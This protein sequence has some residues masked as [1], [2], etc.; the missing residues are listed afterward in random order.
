VTSSTRRRQPP[1]DADP[2]VGSAVAAAAA[3]LAAAAS[4]LALTLAHPPVGAWW[5]TFAAAPLLLLALHLDASAAERDGRAV[6]SARLGLVMGAAAFG[7]M[8]SWLILPAG[9]L[10]W[11]LLVATQAA[12]MAVLAIVLRLALGHPALP[13]VAAVAWV[14]VDAW[15][16]VVPLNGFEWGAIAYAH[17][18]GSWMLPVARLVGGRGI[19]FLVVVVGVAAFVMVRRTVAGL[20]ARESGPF[21][22]ALGPT[23]APAALLVGGLLVSVLATIEPPAEDGSLDI[24][25]V[26][27]NDIRHWEEPADD[28]PLTITTNLRDDTVAAVER[29]GSPDLTVWPESSIDRD[30]ATPRGASLAPLVDDAAAASGRLLAGASLDG[31]DPATE[32]FV[33]GLLFD[34]AA[35]AEIDRYVKR[36]LVPFGEYVPFR[37]VIGWFPPL[38]QI[39]RDAVPGED[40]QAVEVVDGVRAAVVVCFE[41]LFS[42]VVRTNVLADDEPAELLVTITNDAS[43]GISAEPAQHLAQ[44]RLRAVETGRWAVHAALSGSSAFIDPQGA[45]YQDTPLFERATIR[46]DVPLVEGRTPFLV[47]GDWLG[48]G[49]RLAV[50]GMVAL[51]A[52]GA[53]RRRAAAGD[54]DA[55]VAATDAAPGAGRR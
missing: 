47:L 7:P 20:R 42:D 38:E 33:T 49:G 54:L 12:W 16:A 51:A 9:Y 29:D 11:A 23:R 36:R 28:A 15:R 13:V 45:T 31:P 4:G 10:G 40:P 39:P 52:I 27:G 5:L 41:T 17:V 55:A 32:R 25:V 21:E 34:G 26:Q 37:P 18:D 46:M 14:G 19:T 48:I 1:V 3:P 8:L 22:D 35:D 2:A 30:P 43:F 44:T 24:L 50:L 53:R 6:R